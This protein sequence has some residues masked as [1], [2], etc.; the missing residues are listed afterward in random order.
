MI[1]PIQTNAKIHVRVNMFVH[2]Y[3]TYVFIFFNYICMSTKS[4]KKKHLP[5]YRF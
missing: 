3:S 1:S 4:K 5:D 2:T